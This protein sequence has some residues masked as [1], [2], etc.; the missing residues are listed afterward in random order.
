MSALGIS[1]AP[2]YWHTRKLAVT[3]T[4][5][6]FVPKVSTGFE[7]RENRFCGRDATWKPTPDCYSCESSFFP[8][9]S[10]HCEYES[11]LFKMSTF[12]WQ[13]RLSEEIQHAKQRSK[14][15]IA[16]N[17]LKRIEI[18]KNFYTQNTWKYWNQMEFVISSAIFE[19]K[20]QKK[21][22]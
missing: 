2:A 8:V 14:N 17:A 11:Y 5:T 10:K 1:Y 13:T 12:Y 9:R 6:Y 22:L 3:K 19:K 20:K 7:Y 15:G 21:N 18:W 4:Y 16:V